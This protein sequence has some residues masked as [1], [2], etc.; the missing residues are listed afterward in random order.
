[1][2]L[3][4]LPSRT[5]FGRDRARRRRKHV[6]GVGAVRDMQGETRRLAR[7]S[8]DARRGVGALHL[9]GRNVG[10][11]EGLLHRIQVLHTVDQRRVA[12]PTHVEAVPG[13]GAAIAKRHVRV[14]IRI[15]EGVDRLLGIAHQDQ[16]MRG[17]LGEGALQDA[18][19]HRI[20]VLHLVHDHHL[21]A[22]AQGA[23]HGAGIIEH[24]IA[25]SRDQVVEHQRARG[26]PVGKQPAQCVAHHGVEGGLREFARGITQGLKQ[27]EQR[28]PSRAGEQRVRRGTLGC[29]RR[30]A[31]LHH[32]I[33]EQLL[34]GAAHLFSR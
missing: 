32:R 15:A 6:V 1:M 28:T 19:L 26:G 24:G 4:D 30:N 25:Q 12:A 34:A 2:R 20:G 9:H 23:R 33:V 7:R 21:E 10:A 31:V 11:Q 8:V 17:R 29:R 13:L 3:I 14:D 27:A 22:F 18:G 16:S 5:K